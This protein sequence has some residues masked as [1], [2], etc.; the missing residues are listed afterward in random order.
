MSHLVDP[1][2][3]TFVGHPAPGVQTGAPGHAGAAQAGHAAAQSVVADCLFNL[4]FQNTLMAMSDNEIIKSVH[5]PV[6]G[7]APA[8]TG[9][10]PPGSPCREA[11]NFKQLARLAQDFE[12]TA[13]HYGRIVRVDAI[14]WSPRGAPADPA[15]A[16]RSSPK[17]TSLTTPRRS[18]LSV[19]AASRV[20]K[21]EHRARIGGR[22][23]RA[24]QERPA[25]ACA[26]AD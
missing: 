22:G 14:G 2:D 5:R 26:G 4:E 12:H 13:M 24:G 20:G 1:Y 9:L 23:W 7:P 25:S 17:S 3:P 6:A 21:S 10:A 15:R 11:E 8:L 18:G 16:L 19:S